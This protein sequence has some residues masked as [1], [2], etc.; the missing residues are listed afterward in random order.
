[1]KT[2][3]EMK[4]IYEANPVSWIVVKDYPDNGWNYCVPHWFNNNKYKLIHI[5][6]EQVLDAYLADSSVYIEF[7][8][9]ESDKWIEQ[10][11]DFIE[12]YNPDLEYRLKEQ[13]DE[14]NSTSSDTDT[15]MDNSVD[16]DNKVYK[17]TIPIIEVDEASDREIDEYLSKRDGYREMRMVTC[18]SCGLSSVSGLHT[19]RGLQFGTEENEDEHHESELDLNTFTAHGF[20]VPGF[21][22][23]ILKE[24][25]VGDDGIATGRYMGWIRIGNNEMFMVEWW[26]DGICRNYRNELGD[27]KDYNLTPIKKHWYDDPLNFPVRLVRDT[28]YNITYRWVYKREEF[29]KSHRRGFKLVTEDNCT[30]IRSMF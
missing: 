26:S 7:Y 29:V 28:E 14:D 21:D 24:V 18:K 30:L 8:R 13:D 12:N 9:K 5:K 2:T 25:K 16:A 27:L 11:R 10:V 20:E 1:M 19:C 22:G 6:H 23:E 3:E 17:M 4:A 15:T